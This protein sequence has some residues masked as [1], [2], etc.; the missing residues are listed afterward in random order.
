MFKKCCS[1]LYWTC[2]TSIY[3]TYIWKRK[4]VFSSLHQICNPTK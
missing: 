2:D 1:I 4:C 3:V